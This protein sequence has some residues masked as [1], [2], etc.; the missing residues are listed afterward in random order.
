VDHDP[1]KATVLAMERMDWSGEYKVGKWSRGSDSDASAYF[2]KW[3]RSDPESAARHALTSNVEDRQVLGQMLGGVYK[4]WREADPK[5][6]EEW[7]ESL[8]SKLPLEDVQAEQIDLI[9]KTD[10]AR[11]FARRHE[12]ADWYQQWPILS[13]W[14]GQ[15][16][17]AVIA[18]LDAIASSEMVGHAVSSLFPTTEGA[19]LGQAILELSADRQQSPLATLGQKW[20]NA[21]P[22]AAEAFADN[23]EQPII[24]RA[25]LAQV[26]AAQARA[27]P[28]L[29][30]PRLEAI[31]D[32]ALREGVASS[33]ATAWARRDEDAAA[34]WYESL[35]PSSSKAAA[36]RTLIKHS[37]SMRDRM[38]QLGDQEE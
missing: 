34:S 24:R 2:S 28:A 36:L 26:Y 38:S 37:E 19:V 15:D 5:A 3:S 10:P 11:A 27:N 32:A 23:I 6:A 29:F 14:I 18:P 22:S 4:G 20:G 33:L 16:G 35:K 8:D 21:E 31:G 30:S 13:K 25:Y 1:G 9:A 12:S 17:L 7:I